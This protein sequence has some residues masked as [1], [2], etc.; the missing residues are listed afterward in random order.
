[1]KFEELSSMLEEF[2]TQGGW[3]KIQADVDSMRKEALVTIRNSA[4]AR[5]MTAKEPVCHFVRGFI[6]GIS[7]VMFHCST[8]CIETKC[9]AKGDPYCDSKLRENNNAKT[10]HLEAKIGREMNEPEGITSKRPTV[11]CAR[12]Y[13]YKYGR[14]NLR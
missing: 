9:I 2:F 6:T 1:M 13:C 7:D 14:I 11:E 4:T 8:E 12:F 10:C 3:G 5:N